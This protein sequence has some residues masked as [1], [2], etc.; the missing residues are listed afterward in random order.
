MPTAGTGHS[1][2]AVGFGA[3]GGEGAEGRGAERGEW[4]AERGE[5]DQCLHGGECGM[6]GEIG[7]GDP[8]GVGETEFG[9]GGVE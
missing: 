9:G 1:G 3:D 7:E 6:L 5:L 8:L 4:L 2:G